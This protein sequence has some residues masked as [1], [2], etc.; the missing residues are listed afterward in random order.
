VWEQVF[1]IFMRVDSRRLQ[2]TKKYKDEKFSLNKVMKKLPMGRVST[3]NAKYK[4]NYGRNSP[5]NWRII[6]KI[7]CVETFT[8]NSSQ[9]IPGCERKFKLS[10]VKSHPTKES[11]RNTNK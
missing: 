8:N 1:K 10:E 2:F 6:I 9:S 11:T 4:K 7:L 3:A 5:G